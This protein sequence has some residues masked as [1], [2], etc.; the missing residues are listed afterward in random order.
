MV[1]QNSCYVNIALDTHS[2]CG[3]ILFIGITLA[4]LSL[5]GYMPFLSDL[6][7]IKDKGWL[8]IH[9]IEISEVSSGNQTTCE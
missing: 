5:E 3:P 6:F 1:T 7:M 2:H 8:I 9:L 4:S